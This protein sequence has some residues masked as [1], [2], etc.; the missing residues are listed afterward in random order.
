MTRNVCVFVTPS[1]VDVPLYVYVCFR[2]TLS[3]RYALKICVC[4]LPD[5]DLFNNDSYIR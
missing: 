5:E 4:S 3:E 2:D 1:A